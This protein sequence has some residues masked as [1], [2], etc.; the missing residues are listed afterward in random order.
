MCE[1]EMEVGIVNENSETEIEC[2]SE[3]DGRNGMQE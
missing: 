1:S 2:E 3:V